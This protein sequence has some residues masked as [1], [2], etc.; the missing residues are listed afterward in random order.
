MLTAYAERR[1]QEI[2]HPLLKARVPWAMVPHAQARIL[3]RYL[4]GDI[5]QYV[6]FL[7]R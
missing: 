6:P 4:R 3:A 2:E 7:A 5:P 1:R